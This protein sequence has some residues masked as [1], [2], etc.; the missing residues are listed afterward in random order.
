MPL[1]PGGE[2]LRVA[3]RLGLLRTP[4]RGSH[5]FVERHLHSEKR[6]V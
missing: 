3:S 2:L 4:P 5:E 6:L 1:R